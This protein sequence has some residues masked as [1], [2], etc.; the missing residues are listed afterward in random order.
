M[1]WLVGLLSSAANGKG[2]T[3]M[4]SLLVAPS[5]TPSVC[6]CLCVCLSGTLGNN[7]LTDFDKIFQ[8]TWDM[9]K[10]TKCNMLAMLRVTHWIMAFFTLFQGK[11]VGGS[12]ITQKITIIMAFHQTF[13]M[14]Y[15][16]HKE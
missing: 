4:F 1:T 6:L 5:V 15:I 12:S 14:I 8:N 9:T 13:R 16:S 2:Y 3:D 10:E 7:L 11:N